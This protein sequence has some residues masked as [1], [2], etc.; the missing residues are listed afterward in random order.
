MPEPASIILASGS[1]ARRQLLEEAGVVFRVRPADIDERAIQRQEEEEC[2]RR[3]VSL[4][5]P[6]LARALAAAKSQ[7]VSRLEPDALTIGSDQILDLAGELF[8]KP[9][10]LV[11]ARAQL[12]KLSGKTHALHSAIVISRGGRIVWSD[13]RSARLTMRRLDAAEIDDYLLRAGERILGSVGA[14]QIEGEGRALFAAVE[15]DRETIMGLPMEPL[16]AALQRFG[17]LRT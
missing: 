17:V 11:E 13:L 14:Y 6:D 9:R 3:G 2:R 10:D 7:A 8:E 12:S 16:L 1:S 15:G 5:P 4:S